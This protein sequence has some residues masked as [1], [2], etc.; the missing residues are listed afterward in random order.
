M[1]EEKSTSPDTSQVIRILLIQRFD[2]EIMGGFRFYRIL[3]LR[4]ANAYF[5]Q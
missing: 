5:N 4:K 2:V 1:L 3:L